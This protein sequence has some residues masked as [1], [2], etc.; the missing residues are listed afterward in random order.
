MLKYLRDQEKKPSW[1]Y[2]EILNSKG[3]QMK[4]TYLQ[5]T[6]KNFKHLFLLL[7]CGCFFATV[8][9]A[10][11]AE[12]QLTPKEVELQLT[13]K[14]KEFARGYY[15]NPK[16]D[17][18]PTFISENP[19]ISSS[20]LYIAEYF[21]SFITAV[22]K[23]NPEKIDSWMKQIKFKNSL[24]R[25]LIYRA[26]RD[27]N[28]KE[29][30][31]YLNKLKTGGD[32]EILDA[33]ELATASPKRD[34][35][36]QEISYDLGEDLGIVD[37]LWISYDASGNGEYL[38]K[39]L[40]YVTQD[41]TIFS[42]LLHKKTEDPKNDKEFHKGLW[43]DIVIGSIESRRRKDKDLSEKIDEII[44]SKPEWSFYPYLLLNSHLTWKKMIYRRDG[45]RASTDI[46]NG[47]L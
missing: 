43:I 42:R 16:H 7:C 22:A 21:A 45:Y 2:L 29:A 10:T 11:E 35:L 26:I 25:T 9:S 34:I 3:R 31:E 20:T 15:K 47:E 37:H 17:Q 19:E 27:S 46:E 12:R 13:P 32:K 36:K 39:I 30:T 1:Q 33:L 5:K 8:A 14:I 4:N 18:I 38:V 24:E 6:K 44:K 23:K 28:T 40:E 41:P